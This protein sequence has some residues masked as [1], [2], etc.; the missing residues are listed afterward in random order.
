MSKRRRAAVIAACALLAAVILTWLVMPPVRI[1]IAERAA[2]DQ[3]G[4]PYVFGK[5]GPDSF[6]CSGL[7]KYA[8]GKVGVELAHNT[9]IVAGDDRYRTIEDPVKLRRGD[10]VYFDTVSGG[11]K[12]DHVGFWLGGNRF[13]H[14][15]SA[16]HV[17]MISDFD[18]KWQK[19]FSW[20]KR[21]L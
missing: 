14:A 15:S 13:V 21:V 5:A 8:Y 17:V 1:G 20:A 9:K 2:L 12:I 4:K 6:D 16:K 10:L 7:M 11:S 18:E 19:R 3:L